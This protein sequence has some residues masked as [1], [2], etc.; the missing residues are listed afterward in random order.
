MQPV[1]G[2]AHRF[3]GTRNIKLGQHHFYPVVQIG[4]NKTAVSTLIESLEPTMLEALYHAR[5]VMCLSTLV[6]HTE[7][8]PL[9]PVEIMPYMANE[10]GV[11]SG[12]GQKIA[13]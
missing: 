6:N 13:L 3:G 8:I 10:S 2:K 11:F 12:E 4:S 7:R 1:V 9:R 5:G